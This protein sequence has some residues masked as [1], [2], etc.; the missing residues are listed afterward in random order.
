MNQANFYAQLDESLIDNDY[1]QRI[2]ERQPDID[3]DEKYQ[4]EAR[5]R[6]VGISRGVGIY[7]VTSNRKRKTR[8]GEDTN[9]TFQGRYVICRNKESNLICS[10]CRKNDNREVVIFHGDNCRDCFTKHA[11]SVHNY[12]TG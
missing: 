8:D 4:F 5:A 1:D 9:M 10:G 6:G 2:T 3:I 7:S 12:R 11:V